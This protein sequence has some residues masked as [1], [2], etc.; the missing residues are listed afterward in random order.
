[1]SLDQIVNYHE[2]GLSIIPT[3]PKDKRPVIPQWKTYQKKLPEAEDLQKWFGNGKDNAPAMIA[4][5]I[6]GN[7][8]CF[9]F[10]N[11]AEA[12]PDFQR[13]VE[14]E[15][16][17]IWA[18]LV[19]QTTQGSG[20]HGVLRSKVPVPGNAKLAQKAVEVPGPGKH[21]VEGKEYV[22]RKI[23]DKYY[24][25]ITLIE[26]RGE[27]GYFLIDPAPGY[28]LCKGSW[29]DLQPLEEEEV[30]Y[31][32]D[33]AR[34]LN[35]FIPKTVVR[36]KKVKPPGPKEGL[37]PWDDFN[38]RVSPIQVLMESGWTDT[39]RGGRTP[40][41]G[42]TILVRRPEKTTGHSGSVIDNKLFWTW[43]TSTPFET[44]KIYDAF[45]VYAVLKHEGDQSAAAKELYKKGYGEKPKPVLERTP[46]GAYEYTDMG[47][48][49]RFADAVRGSMMFCQTWNKW[50]KYNGIRWAFERK[51]EVT[52]EAKKVVRDIINDIK[53]ARDDEQVEQIQKWFKKS[54]GLRYI[55]AMMQLAKSEEGIGVEPEEID[56][57]VWLLNTQNGTVNL[58]T[59]DVLPNNPADLI[60]Q[61][62]PARCDP[63]AQC[64]TWDKFLERIFGGDKDL[65]RFVQKAAGYSLTGSDREQVVFMLHGQGQNGK[66]TFL[67]TIKRVMGTY[68]KQ[69]N[70][71]TFLDT[72]KSETRNDIADLKGARL[73]C[74]I[75]AEKGSRMAESVIKQMTG[76]DTLKA[77]FLYGENFEFDVTFKIWL[78]CNH[79]PVIRGNDHAIWRRIRLIPFEQTIQPHEVDKT[80]DRKLLAETDGIL[81]WMLEGTAMWQEEGLEMP[82]VVERACS[83]YRTDMDKMEEF[84]SEVCVVGPP[85]LY[86]V[87]KSKL[88]QAYKTW[89]VEEGGERPL[90][91]KRFG[92]ELISRGFKD[93]RNTS[94]RWWK[95]ISVAD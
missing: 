40:R 24:A 67:N 55:N 34:S 95:G 38:G 1:M 70:F 54:Q 49:E 78:A 53:K 83:N 22:A 94:K 6:S 74:A 33:V 39:G 84:L 63:N 60:M 13:I 20:G 79:R 37:T 62:V 26:T 56:R 65:I 73:V 90:A 5:A 17:E 48:G 36:D 9:D 66:S 71:T 47:N 87:S 25:V 45:G 4:G 93:D 59:G 69:A 31:L 28:R 68:A 21:M 7:V 41:G 77:R 86:T 75:E 30:N 64:P 16:P 12:L 52:K 27:G 29:E 82:D 18:K 92:E 10:D 8:L 35:Q 3:K 50:L 80:L 32:L 57:D 85:E 88:Y 15:R 58:R 2:A 81:R 23:N 61:E 43:S 42:E 44:E 72:Q 19:L 76:G 91:K 46:Q 11:R 89:C 51:N 14:K